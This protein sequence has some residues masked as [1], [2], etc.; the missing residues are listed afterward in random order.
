MPIRRD[1]HGVRPINEILIDGRQPWRDKLLNTIKANYA[2]AA[3]FHDVFPLVQ[4][5]ISNQT[6]SLVDYNVSAVISIRGAV[7][8][9]DR[10]FVRSSSLGVTTRAIDRLI[11]LVKAVGGTSYLAGGGAAGSN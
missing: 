7:C 5:L 3:H 2:H 9:P 10:P 6:E 4:Q 11:D 8:L 1:Y